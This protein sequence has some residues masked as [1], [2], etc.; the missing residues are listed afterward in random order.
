MGAEPT[1]PTI[2]SSLAGVAVATTRIAWVDPVRGAFVRGY[3][4]AELA[5]RESYERI[6][7]L[8]LRGELPHQATS[9]GDVLAESV[10]EAERPSIARDLGRALGSEQ[11]LVAAMPLIGEDDWWLDPPQA[12]PRLVG[13]IP[14]VVAA[15]GGAPP[16][17]RGSYAARALHALGA[18]RTDAAALRALEVLLALEAEHG[19]SASTFACRVAA[20]S[21]ASPAVAL[22]AACATLSG[23]RHG[24]ATR[25]AQA[26]LSS[27]AACND[28]DA[29]VRSRR[30]QKQVFP[31]FG[32]RI[33]KG[34]DPRLPPLR[35]AI[36]AMSDVPLQK[37]ACDLEAAVLRV[38]APKVLRANIDLWGA[39]L[40]DALGVEPSMYVAAFALGV[41]CGWLAHFEE[42]LGEGRLVRPESAYAGPPERHL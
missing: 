10:L 28:V 31:G 6:A 17:P 1:S 3:S 42:Q 30:A 9:F 4:L 34:A 16:P 33:Y 5:E 41:G 7:H 26:L 24:G 36:L 2:D 25:D 11:G 27:V 15:V 38:F 19:L 18:K 35:S 37:A 40:L 20:S 22:A 13:R 12:M 32:H 14:A 23:P 29:L 39:V 21:G 8:V